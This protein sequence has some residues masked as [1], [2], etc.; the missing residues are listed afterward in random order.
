M[1]ERPRI[2]IVEDDAVARD[3]YRLILAAEGYLVSTAA[4]S[5]AALA[6]LKRSPPHAIVLDLHLSGASGLDLLR[7]IRRNAAQPRP[8]VAIVTA[9]YLLDE[10]V[11]QELEQLGATIWF[12]PLW[13]DDLLRLAADLVAGTAGGP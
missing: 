12:K 6:E 11:P 3:T 7:E 1:A 5:Q 2:L 13:D 9:D 8:S 10:A 4:D